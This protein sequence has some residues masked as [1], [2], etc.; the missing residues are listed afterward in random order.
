MIAQTQTPRQ[1]A[2]AREAARKAA[3]RPIGLKALRVAIADGGEVRLG[4]VLRRAL[5][6]W[7][8]QLFDKAGQFVAPVR[9]TAVSQMTTNEGLAVEARRPGV[10]R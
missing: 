4:T 2:Q 5:P 3:P 6:D 1:R 9:G 10:N 8:W 7:E